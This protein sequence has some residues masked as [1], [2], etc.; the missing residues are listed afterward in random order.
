M[1]KLMQ[2]DGEKWVEIAKNGV[3]G[4]DALVN[5]G[6]ILS[7]IPTPENGKDGSPDLPQDIAFKLNTLKGAVDVSVIKGAVAKKDLEDQDKKV[8]DGMAKIDGRIKLIDQ[9]WGGHGGGGSTNAVTSVT[10]TLPIISS[11]GKTPNI[12]TSMSTN[13]LIGRGTAGTGVMEEITLGTNL[14][15]S[16]TTLNAA[17]STSPLTTKGDLFG[18]STVDARIPVG[19]NAQV[20]TADSTQALGVK[21]ATPTTGT[22]TSI[23]T[24]GLLSG[25]PIT[26]SGTITTSIATNKLVGRSTAGTGVFEAISVG[27][28]LTLSGGTLSASAGSSVFLIDGSDNI[29]SSNAGI[30]GGSKNFINGLGAAGGGVL[31]GDFNIIE[32][33]LAGYSS[34]SA[35]GNVIIGPIAGNLNTDGDYNTFLGSYAGYTNSTGSYNINIGHGSVS[36]SGSASGQL[37]I[38]SLLYGTGLYK[39]AGVNSDVVQE[40]KLGLGTKSPAVRHHVIG[41]YATLSDPSFFNASVTAESL[42]STTPIDTETLIYQPVAPTSAGLGYD[43]VQTTGTGNYVCNGQTINVT[44]YE[45]RT[46]GG[47]DYI[48]PVGFP[49]SYVDTINDGTTFFLL[50]WYWNYSNNAD[51]SIP[52]FLIFANAT[53]GF[54][55][56][57]TGGTNVTFNDTDTDPGSVPTYSTF[58]GFSA[59]GQTFNFDILSIGTSPSG[60]TYYSMTTT[61]SSVTDMLGGGFLFQIQHTIS[62]AGSE[63]WKILQSGAGSQTGANDFTFYQDTNFAG[64]NTVTPN[65]YGFLSDGSALNHSFTDTARNVSRGEFFSVGSLSSTTVD[66]NDGL[67]YYINVVFNN[68]TAEGARLTED[69]N[70]R[71]VAGATGSV[72]I[73]ALGGTFVGNPIP[74]FTPTFRSYPAIYA[75]NTSDDT[76]PVAQLRLRSTNAN[77]QQGFEM[78][79]NNTLKAYQKHLQGGN[80]EFMNSNGIYDFVTLS[81]SGPTINFKNSSGTFIAGINANGV[82]LPVQAATASAPTY[83]K[84]GIYFD[85]TLNKMRIGGASGW[86]TITSI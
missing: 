31:V 20:L 83:V 46:I 2:Y 41:E 39:Q 12:S 34:T 53:T 43:A 7:Q 47:T 64:S 32:G 8:L 82:F 25:G 45:G 21:W 30:P 14:S 9:R 80:Y 27:T 72:S 26:S 55:Y 13:K 56:R 3:D 5:Y 52:D 10:A 38:G 74:P 19:S 4:K 18:H 42:V 73:D 54:I 37:N 36:A 17:G 51:G 33:Y 69:S 62:S 16:G 44:V 78:Y 57:I 70:Y 59:S 86:E 50:N 49:M 15:L 71:D 63:G 65:H 40:A 84:G 6:Y 24:A 48:D 35:E 75:E 60:N 61:S 23:G 22:V 79:E 29:Y 1:S 28:G 81:S 76:Y 58:T 77:G 68:G 67:Y 66:P 11:L 85:L